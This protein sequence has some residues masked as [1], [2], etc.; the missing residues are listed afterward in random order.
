MAVAKFVD[1]IK[2]FIAGPYDDEYEDDYDEYEDDEEIEEYRP[3]SREKR[4]VSTRRNKR[5]R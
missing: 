4:E 5:E 2:D 1:K 3:H